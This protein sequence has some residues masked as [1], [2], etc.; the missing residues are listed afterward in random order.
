M[1]EFLYCPRHERLYDVTEHQWI[2]FRRGDVRLVL[3]LYPR[4][5][6]LHIRHHICDVCIRVSLRC[7][8][9][10]LASSVARGPVHLVNPAVPEDER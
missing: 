9:R 1:V 6:D 7:W 4:R 3:T 10:Q 8:G 2:P 5:G